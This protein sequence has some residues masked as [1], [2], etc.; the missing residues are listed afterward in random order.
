MHLAPQVAAVRLENA[1]PHL[2]KELQRSHFIKTSPTSLDNN[3]FTLFSSWMTMSLGK[4]P[5][6]VYD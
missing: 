5:G 2:C 4:N 6:T 3:S 1:R